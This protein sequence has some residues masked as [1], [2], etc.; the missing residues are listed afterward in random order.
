MRGPFIVRPT[1]GKDGTLID[2][3]LHLVQEV[4]INA[5]YQDRAIDPWSRP[6]FDTRTR[7]SGRD[8]PEQAFTMTCRT[9]LRSLRG[10]CEIVLGER[11]PGDLV[12]TGIWRGS[13]CIMVA[14]VLAAYEIKDRK[15]W[16]F[17][18]FQGLLPPNEA[19]YPNDRGD[20]L[21]C[22]PQ[23]AVSIEEVTDNFRRVGLWSDQIRRSDRRVATD[24]HR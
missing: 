12:E 13:A 21:H 22:S 24:E 16:G 19:K 11:I 15:V 17:D 3:Y 7:D 9:R 1:R 5:I 2:R 6:T 8:W 20:Q 4:L 18:S 10:G 23:L 14:A